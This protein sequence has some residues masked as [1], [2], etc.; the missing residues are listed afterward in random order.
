MVATTSYRSTQIGKLF[1]GFSCGIP[2]ICTGSQSV[3]MDRPE[4]KALMK[5]FGEAADAPQRSKLVGTPYKDNLPYLEE[6]LKTVM[7]NCAVSFGRGWSY[8]RTKMLTLLKEA[9][10]RKLSLNEMNTLLGEVT[11]RGY[12]Q[13]HVS[14]EL[15]QVSCRTKTVSAPTLNVPCPAVGPPPGANVPRLSR[16]DFAGRLVLERVFGVLG[17][18]KR[19]KLTGTPFAAKLAPLLRELQMVTAEF[20][21]E[22]EK[23]KKQSFLDRV[24]GT[25]LDGTDK[26]L[27]LAVS[28]DSY[29]EARKSQENIFNQLFGE[30]ATEKCHE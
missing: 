29:L 17:S 15:P 3:Q 5:I 24:F 9:F 25:R 28:K 21:W 16:E 6:V 7:V 30:K 23:R 12:M 8:Q 19:Q 27:L 18:E 4:G 26:E 11:L 10:G 22:T 14:C 1:F 2:F 13:M 20:D